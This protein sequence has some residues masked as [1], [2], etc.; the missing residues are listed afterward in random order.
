MAED[1]KKQRWTSTQPG[2]FRT[3]LQYFRYGDTTV[4]RAIGG[5]TD[6]VLTIV[7]AVVLVFYL[8]RESVPFIMGGLAIVYVIAGVVLGFVYFRVQLPSEQA[9]S[10]RTNP[11]F[12]EWVKAWIHLSDAICHIA[13]DT[14][15][16]EGLSSAKEALQIL[17]GLE[18]DEN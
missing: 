9:R 7:L 17:E 14:G 11:Y 16:T 6:V 15:S 5:F 8:P 18:F 2:K 3:V 4:L 10:M 1:N 12:R 13:S